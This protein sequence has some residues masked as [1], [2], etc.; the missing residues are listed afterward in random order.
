M[1]KA[2][3]RLVAA[4]LAAVVLLSAG[5][6]VTGH[7]DIDPLPVGTS[8]SSTLNARIA[9]YNSALTALKSRAASVMSQI[10]ANQ[11]AIAAHNATV[12]SYPNRQAPPAVADQLNA[13]AARLNGEKARLEGEL[14]AVKADIAKLDA[15]RG[16]IEAAIAAERNVRTKALPPPHV[17]PQP[18]NQ[19]QRAPRPASVPIRPQAQS[20]GNPT[21]NPKSNAP[22]QLPPE[23]RPATVTGPKG[24]KFPGVPDGAPAT[25]TKNG[26]GYVYPLGPVEGFDPRVVSI[27]VMR[28]VSY[29]GGHDYPN[30][31]Y[32]YLN[33]NGQVVNPFTGQQIHDKT[34]PYFH[35]PLDP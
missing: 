31:Y 27:R 14:A 28:P 22:K 4:L 21:H 8:N 19:Y 15:E 23:I 9:A 2:L 26:K 5:P 1:V 12:D 35:I 18:G 29:Q 34:D 16:A 32:N 20:G 11:Q 25:P 24:E 17:A 13:E 7:A 10:D 30:G 3:C 6:A 33:V